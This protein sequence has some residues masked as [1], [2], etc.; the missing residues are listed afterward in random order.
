M[1]P[2]GPFGPHPRLAVGV[3]GGSHSLALALLSHRWARRR[4]GDALGLV[5]DHG[6][7]AESAAEA[8]H[9]AQMLAGQ[10][11]AARVLRL[12]L[13]VGS[14]MQE[15]A[16]GARLSALTAAA[17][18]DGRPWLLLGHH[19][20]DQAETLLFRAL[21]GSGAE[22]LAA[23]APV[24]DAGAA[25]I[26]RPLLAVPPA[27]LEAVV[28]AAGLDP[29]RDPSNRDP[30][31]ARIRL[32]E[33]LADPAGTG[34]AVAALSSAATA[35][36]MR[37][38][39][40]AAALAERLAQAAEIRPEGFARL[41]PAALGRD[42]VAVSVVAWLTALIGGAGFLP[43][44][45]RAA[46][47][48]AAGGGTLAGAW[49][50]PAGGGTWLLARDPGAVAAPVE[51]RPGIVWDARFRLLGPGRPGWSIGALGRDAAR[52]RDHVP[53]PSAVL[54]AMPAIRDPNGMLAALPGM[55]YPSSEACAPFAVA[56][57]PILTG[58]AGS[59]F[60]GQPFKG[61]QPDPMFHG[62]GRAG[63]PSGTETD[64]RT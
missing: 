8:L 57:A 37:R 1:A 48:L 15:R 5:A 54:Q 53:L 17:N 22:G 43:A 61:R 6:L 35:F 36:A 62:E 27:A 58:G 11:I 52:L 51:A 28:A 16:R 30:R 45:D 12:G 39:R 56:F 55:D 18:Q 49:L 44:R 3:S 33:A 40:A 59:E 47:L 13:A 7:R 41:D 50:R 10:G 26:L 19:R 38:A 34:A 64:K 4:G 21:R 23:M 24:R 46:A 14:G 2:L 9:V 25:L 63:D 20:G 31:F 32:R 42:G 29:V 60:S